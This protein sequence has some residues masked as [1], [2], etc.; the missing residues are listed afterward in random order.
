MR[1]YP[2]EPSSYIFMRS[3]YPLNA[4]F[5]KLS[6]AFG[7]LATWRLEIPEMKGKFIKPQSTRTHRYQA[8][9]FQFPGPGQRL[10]TFMINYLD[11]GARSHVSINTQSGEEGVIVR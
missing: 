3:I 1:V 11:Y 2:E 6:S 4:N 5:A 7:I 8:D 10:S 9:V